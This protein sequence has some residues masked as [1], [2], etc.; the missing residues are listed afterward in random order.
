MQYNITVV[1]WDKKYRNGSY[2]RSKE[3]HGL[4]KRFWQI[5]PGKTVIDVASGRG[6]DAAFLAEKGFTV[7]GLEKSMEAI[8][9]SKTSFGSTSSVRRK[10]RM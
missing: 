9:I 7:F 6:R 1:D 3:P 8:Y 5:I 10:V 2:D 4:L